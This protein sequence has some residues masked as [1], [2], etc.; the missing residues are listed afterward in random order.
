MPFAVMSFEVTF[1]VEL[2]KEGEHCRVNFTRSLFR[3]AAI[4][5]AENCPVYSRS[6][7]R[8]IGF[9]QD[10]CRAFHQPIGAAVWPSI[11]RINVQRQHIARPLAF[12]LFVGTVKLLIKSVAFHISPQHLAQSHFRLTQLWTPREHAEHVRFGCA[13]RLLALRR[14]AKDKDEAEPSFS[15]ALGL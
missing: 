10:S 6:A 13:V 1:R 15:T 14:V 9:G 8:G 3:D 4:V 12:P 2:V 11:I 5:F 7:D